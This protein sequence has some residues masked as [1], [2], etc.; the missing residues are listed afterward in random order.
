MAMDSGDSD[1]MREPA[2]WM[3][4]SDD[5]ILELLRSEGNLNPGA[6]DEF[7]GPE[8]SWAG[9]RLAR[10]VEA[11]L[12]EKVHHGIYRITDEGHAYLEEELDAS[13]L[14]VPEAEQVDDGD[15]DATDGA[16]S[17]GDTPPD[18]ESDGGQ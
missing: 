9:K 15:D 14:P 16:D 11:G 12:V 1:D 5:R 7:G 10:L 4:R 6:I 13:T 3:T 2:D 17:S 18:S 8:S